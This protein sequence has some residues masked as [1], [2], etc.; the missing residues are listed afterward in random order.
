MINMNR[1]EIPNAETIAAIFDV[2]NGELITY[3]QAD[4]FF[5]KLK[6]SSFTSTDLSRSRDI[7]LA[8]SFGG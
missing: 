6:I 7:A 3:K 2:E 5:E 1:S 8:L 4:D